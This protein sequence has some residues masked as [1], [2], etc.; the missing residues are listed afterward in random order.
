MFSEFLT[1][2]FQKITVARIHKTLGYMTLD[3]AI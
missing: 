3:K 2:Y 1:R